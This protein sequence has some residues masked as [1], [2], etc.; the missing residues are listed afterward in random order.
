MEFFK[1]TAIIEAALSVL[2]LSSCGSFS[3][4]SNSIVSG[5]Y[6]DRDQH[7]IVEAW[8]LPAEIIFRPHAGKLGDNVV[9]WVYYL[10]DDS[11]E[12]APIFYNF[13]D[14]T[15]LATNAFGDGY[16]DQRVMDINNKSDRQLILSERNRFKKIWRVW[17]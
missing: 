5:D 15:P 13:R 3:A 2:V 16:R 17:Q 14:G 8:G 4:S 7:S 10:Q 1:S 6:P 9:T 11:G 12:I